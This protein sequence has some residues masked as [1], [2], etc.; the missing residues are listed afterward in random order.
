MGALN[1][2]TSA[3]VKN[4]KPGKHSDGGGLPERKKYRHHAVHEKLLSDLDAEEFRYLV[5]FAKGIRW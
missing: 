3:Q 5:E 1:K 2:L 4:A